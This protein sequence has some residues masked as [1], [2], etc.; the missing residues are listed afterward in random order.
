MND[1]KNDAGGFWSKAE[2]AKRQETDRARQVSK[3]PTLV[4][5]EKKSR[6]RRVVMWTLAILAILILGGVALAPTIASSFVPGI[7]EG[8]SGKAIAGKLGLESA[9]LS[10]FGP[11]KVKGFRLATPEGTSVATADVDVAAGLFGLARGKLDLGE[12]TIRNANAEI[13]RLPDGTTNLQRAIASAAKDAPAGSS[14]G[15]NAK[16]DPDT[17]LPADLKARVVLTRF[18]ASYEDRTQTNAPKLKVK[19]L[20]GIADIDVGEPSSLDV[21]F[22]VTPDNAAPGSVEMKTKVSSWTRDDGLLT[23]DKLKIAADM[24]ATNV[25]LELLDALAGPVLGNAADGSPITLKRAMGERL[26]LT[27]NAKGT[28]KEGDATFDL[29]SP[30]VTAK[31]SA[32]IADGVLQAS[33]PIR[34]EMKGSSLRFMTPGLDQS[35]ADAKD[36][37]TI[38]AIPDATLTIDKLKLSLPTEDRKADFRGGVVMG[39]ISIGQTTG[40]V[41]LSSGE[42]M[43]PFIIA[44]L[45]IAIDAPDLAG[46]IRVRGGT[47]ATI[48]GQPAGTLAVDIAAQG[49]VDNASG[50]IVAGVP[51]NVQGGLTLRG[52]ATAIVQ[53][54]VGAAGLDLPNDIGPTLNLA[55]NATTTDGKNLA[56]TISGDAAHM[57]LAGAIDVSETLI[58]TRES[59]IQFSL[60]RAG[61]VA[62]KLVKP[63]TGW[64]ISPWSGTQTAGVLNAN[65][66]AMR[67]PLKDGSPD[68]RNATLDVEGSI[69]QLVAAAINPDRTPK[70]GVDLINIIKTDIKASLSPQNGATAD[71]RADLGYAGK[72][73]TVTAVLKS[74]QLFDTAGAVQSDPLKIAPTLTIAATGV[75]P[76]IGSLSSAFA[77]APA[78]QP[79]ARGSTPTPAPAKPDMVAVLNAASGGNMDVQ[80]STAPAKAAETLA[81]TAQVRSPFMKTDVKADLARD[82]VSIG[83]LGGQNGMTPAGYAAIMREFTVAAG[84]ALAA[85]TLVSW[86]VA[87][88]TIPLA[89]GFSPQMQKV[90]NAE[91]RLSIPG[92]LIVNGV[93]VSEAGGVTTDLGGIGV[94]P[95][96][97]IAQVPVAAMNG[98]GL[99][100]ERTLSAKLNGTVLG[101]NRAAL[102]ELDGNITAILSNGAP[103]GACRIVAKLSDV[104]TRV[105]EL[106]AQK[107]GLISG[108]VGSPMMLDLNVNAEPNNKGD[109]AAGTIE[110]EA[111][112]AA[113]RLR[114]SG[115][116]RITMEPGGIRLVKP[117]SFSMDAEP[118]AI[119]A[120]LAPPSGTGEA[121]GVR[122]ATP[123]TVQINVDRFSLPRALPTGSTAKVAPLDLG[124]AIT[125]QS[126]ALASGPVAKPTKVNV[127]GLDARAETEAA[128]KGGSPAVRFRLGIAQA[129][130]DEAPPATNLVASGVVNGL[131]S[132]SG[133]IDPN[134]ATVTA[135]ADIANIPTA[136]IDALANRK[137]E[138]VEGLGPTVAFKLNADRVPLGQTPAASG[139][140]PPIIEAKMESQRARLSLKGTVADGLYR[141]QAPL[142]FNIFELT[143][144][145]SKRYIGVVPLIGTLEKGMKDAPAMLTANNLVVPLSDDPANLNGDILL[146]PGECKFTAGNSFGGLLKAFGQQSDVTVGRRLQPLRVAVRNGVAT[147]DTWAVPAGEFSIETNGRVD[148]VKREVDVITWIPAGALTDR[149]LGLFGGGGLAG[150]LDKL[151]PG[152]VDALMKLPFRTRGS[153]DN[154]K[155]EPDLELYASNVVKNLKPGNLLPKEIG[156]LLKPKL[157]TAPS[158]PGTPTVP[159]PK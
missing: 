95:F 102:G 91:V 158:V 47:D 132:P 1:S 80:I 128:A 113:P 51:R 22:D 74:A 149:A 124:V 126:I 23:L 48:S 70:P 117:A 86:S 7:V 88:L 148:L 36:T 31:G 110:A 99:E 66:R 119:N 82:R 8:Q 150:L 122:L 101:L 136:L 25:P 53:P 68:L 24:T 19:D 13:V 45:S 3:D 62:E 93:L 139:S 40:K 94:G 30:G 17:R 127:T 152:T 108:L 29:A 121:T 39:A 9:S 4:G 83:T 87:P 84:P 37:A 14:P 64:A 73:F 109:F 81:I 140:T 61:K 56:L 10:W 137:G 134:L 104:D 78:P 90:A 151:T 46:P 54:F 20:K 33:S 130:V 144:L 55:A 63:D 76:Q 71:I 92:A 34:A 120:F 133:A 69:G 96:N 123:A 35:L 60:A 32:S 105:A 129:T 98:P 111:A 155:T 49:L 2:D 131:V 89:E 156:D 5:R 142:E 15:D 115:P 135:N 77:A 153:M 52:L 103:S 146:D 44:P 67:V 75:P 59:G 12:V 11:Q 26:N 18:N 107:P 72:P 79:A 85:D 16:K 112:I 154:P 157:P 58:A 6:R 106:L 21:S 27:I 38:D 143:Q 57:T 138:L 116:M 147:Y 159:T 145:F 114:T 65:I 41:R 28:I 42:S 125:A 43:K 97:V 100:S 50:A 118:D 141:S